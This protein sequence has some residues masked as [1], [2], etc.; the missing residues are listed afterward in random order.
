ME[1][2]HEF[3]RELELRLLRCTLPPCGASPRLSSSS[4]MHRP[5][6]LASQVE[7]LVS[8]IEKGN[9]GEVLSSDAA[10]M[11]FDFAEGW[12][13]ENAKECSNRFYAQVEK[14]AENFLKVGAEQRQSNGP[15]MDGEPDALVRGI[16][17]M[18]IAVAAFLAFVQCNLTG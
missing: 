1:E 17:V 3:V 15:T 5:G 13:F 10:R 11:V 18:A 8:F 4:R 7:E 6:S 12:Q 9:Y 14:S 2:S 16:L